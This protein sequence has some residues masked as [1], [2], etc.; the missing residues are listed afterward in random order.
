DMRS[1]RAASI[2]VMVLIGAV[3]GSAPAAMS[4]S[5]WQ[6]FP[7]TKV[8]AGNAVLVPTWA[9]NRVWVLATWG[10]GGTLASARISGRTLASFTARRLS[11][12]D[13][14]GVLSTG[15]PFVD[16]RLV[17]RTGEGRPDDAVAT[18]PLLPDGRLGPSE[19]VPD[20]L[21]ARAMETVPQ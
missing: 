11:A 12:G 8:P 18:A 7:R 14:R 5:P 9:A 20:D 6:L 1:H 16:G 15:D 2:A 3:V 4:K 19:V 21:V 13:V 17:V 10:D